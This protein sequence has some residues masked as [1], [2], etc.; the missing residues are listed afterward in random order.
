MKYTYEW[1]DDETLQK[2]KSEAEEDI[3]KCEKALERD[4]IYMAADKAV[5]EKLGRYDMMGLEVSRTSYFNTVYEYAKLMIEIDKR[6]N[7]K[8]REAVAV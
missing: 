7:S 5:D 4:L 1:Y 3:R 6:K 2:F 8:A